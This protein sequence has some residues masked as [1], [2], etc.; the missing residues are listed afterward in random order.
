MRINFFPYYGCAL[1]IFLD[2]PTLRAISRLPRRLAA[3]LTAVPGRASLFS[4]APAALGTS[5][6]V[7][8][9]RLA[10]AF[11]LGMWGLLLLCIYARIESW[12]LTD[13]GVFAGRSKLS[14]VHIYRLAAVDA[15]GQKMWVPTDWTP[16][17]PTWFHRYVNVR[18][19]EKDDASLARLLDDLAPHVARHDHTGQFQSIAIVERTLDTDSQSGRLLVIDRPRERVSLAGC[20]SRPVV[21]FAQRDVQSDDR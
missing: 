11:I 1:L 3:W 15:S 14:D 16:L 18:L 4:C 2:W 7:G 21:E 8:D 6:I 17:S 5:P 9:T 20:A 19:R 10:R 12:P 13:Y